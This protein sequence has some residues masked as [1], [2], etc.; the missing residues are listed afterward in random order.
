M[1]AEEPLGGEMRR[2]HR[3]TYSVLR[4]ALAGLMRVYFRSEVVGRENI[5]KTGGFILAPVH[6]SYI[7]TPVVTAITPRILR[8]MGGERFF[9]TRIG[10]WFLHCMGGFPVQRGTADREAMR[11]AQMVLE[12]GEPLVMFPEGSRQDGTD[13]DLE[14]MH[15]GPAFI[16]AR[17][18][19]PIVPVGIGGSDRAMPRG[20]K[21]VFPRKLT[22][23]IGRPIPPPE[24]V[25]G[26]VSR[27]R[28]SAHTEQ[29][30]DEIQRL[31]D[32]AR[33]LTR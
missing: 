9:N 24:P 31:Y 1:E 32:E 28:V 16:A 8:F 11:A 7:D 17:A 18:Q 14:V 21:F 25:N 2:S 27:K 23:V 22:F 33:A 30:R 29:V 3:W 5:P 19:V 13:V 4:V 10:A 15:D 12:R 20:A 26:R 6:R